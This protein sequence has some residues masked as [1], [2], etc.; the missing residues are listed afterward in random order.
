MNCAKLCDCLTGQLGNIPAAKFY[1]D[2]NLI[3][4]SFS[5]YNFKQMQEI[6]Y[7]SGMKEWARMKATKAKN[8]PQICLS[9]VCFLPPGTLSTVSE[10]FQ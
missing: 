4:T 6:F 1:K 2:F 3:D 5:E 8:K 10:N 7:L 9:L